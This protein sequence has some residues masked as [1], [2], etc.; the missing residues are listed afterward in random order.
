VKE[1][2]GH[3]KGLTSAAVEA[4]AA[5]IVAAAAAGLTG[6]QLQGT[7]QQLLSEHLGSAEPPAELA[8]HAAEVLSRK[9]KYYQYNNH[10]SHFEWHCG[11]VRLKVGAIIYL[12]CCPDGQGERAAVH[13]CL[14]AA[15]QQQTAFA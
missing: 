8:A 14:A 4:A 12:H 5:A 6:S 2:A 1:K 15:S 7:I 13:C 10:C 9:V 3:V 11:A